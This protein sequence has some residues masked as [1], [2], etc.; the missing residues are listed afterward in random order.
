MPNKFENELGGSISR[1]CESN[2]ECRANCCIKMRHSSHFSELS[3]EE[4]KIVNSVY[5]EEKFCMFDSHCY[6]EE[7]LW[8]A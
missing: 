4:R 6:D 2:D 3:L 7:G 8:V 5:K 1:V